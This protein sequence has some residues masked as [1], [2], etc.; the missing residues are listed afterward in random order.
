MNALE[1][2]SAVLLLAG[3]VFALLGGI[4]LVRFPDVLARLQAATKPQTVGIVIILVGA[5]LQVEPSAVAPLILVGLFQLVT[6]PVVAQTIG[7]VAYRAGAVR[8]EGLTTD[9]LADRLPSRTTE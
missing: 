3:G 4:G 2:A 8:T 7:R 1:V 9:E 6:T 5:A